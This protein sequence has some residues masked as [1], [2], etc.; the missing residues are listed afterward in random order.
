MPKNHDTWSLPRTG[1]RGLR[2]L[3]SK[4]IRE[5]SQAI[6][7][8]LYRC[9][10]DPGV[11]STD[12]IGLSRGLAEPPELLLLLHLAPP[13]CCAA[14]PLEAT[15][16]RPSIF[17]ASALHRSPSCGPTDDTEY[18]RPGQEAHNAA[19]VDADGSPGRPPQ[20]AF[21]PPETAVRTTPVR[22]AT[23]VRTFMLSGAYTKKKM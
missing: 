13:A 2:L 14:I 9:L 16:N 1:W 21:R 19:A 20:A 3:T 23:V 10:D 22:R 11:Y 15:G 5:A 6:S 4:S 17:K 18:G 7:L 8:I 12:L